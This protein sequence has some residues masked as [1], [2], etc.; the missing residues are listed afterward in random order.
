MQESLSV[1][2]RISAFRFDLHFPPEI[3]DVP[4]FA[5]SRFFHQ[6]QREIER[7]SRMKARRHSCRVFYAWAAERKEAARLHYHVVIFVNKDAYFS[8]GAY[9][10]QARKGSNGENPGGMAHCILRSWSHALNISSEAV[11]G[12]I[13]FADNGVYY[14][15]RNGPNSAAQFAAIFQRSSYLAK[16]KTKIYGQGHR[17]FDCSR[18]VETRDIGLPA[19]V[20][21]NFGCTTIIHDIGE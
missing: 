16:A 17:C 19:C 1:Y 15:K 10:K 2:K 6:L 9:P 11:I 21:D 4:S 8:W 18:R 20:A 3:T 7:E 13:H 14:L 5:I 12:S